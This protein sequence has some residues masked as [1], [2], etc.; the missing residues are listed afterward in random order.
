MSDK[1]RKAASAAG[2]YKK[3]NMKCNEPQRAPKGAKQ[4][5]VVKACQGGE[6]KIVRFGARGYEDYLQHKDE[7][8]RANFKARHNCSEKKDK[9]TPGWWACNYNW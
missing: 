1:A 4:K 5:Y 2:K 7:G 3:E 6:E 8:R 9:L